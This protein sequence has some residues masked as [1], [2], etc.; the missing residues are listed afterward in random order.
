MQ[1]DSKYL[2]A[3]ETADRPTT[4]AEQQ[5]IQNQA[6]FSYRMATGELIYV[7]IVA[8]MEISFANIKLSQYNAN[9]ALIHYTALRQIFAYLNKTKKDGLIYWRPGPRDDL[10]DMAIPTPRSLLH[11]QLPAVYH[12]PQ[13]HC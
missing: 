8:R 5:H 4:P 9:P 3:L 10:P 1:N 13:C 7:L 12:H 6:G 2:R 11:N